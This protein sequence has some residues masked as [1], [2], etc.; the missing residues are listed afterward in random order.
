MDDGQQNKDDQ[1]LYDSSNESLT[2]EGWQGRGD[3][4]DETSSLD[5]TLG[6]LARHYQNARGAT[7]TYDPPGEFGR[8]RESSSDDGETGEMPMR[9]LVADDIC[10]VNNPK[11]GL[12]ANWTATVARDGMTTVDGEA[13]LSVRWQDQPS[14]LPFNEPRKFLWHT[15]DYTLVPRRVPSSP[16]RTGRDRSQPFGI[17]H[18]NDS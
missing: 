13:M 10:F 18:P 5:S 14:M 7:V 2:A 6:H 1:S 4:E 8:E 17:N 3:S 16:N 9:I 12:K 11:Y 15:G